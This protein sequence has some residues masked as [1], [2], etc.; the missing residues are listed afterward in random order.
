MP[1]CLLGD[2]CTAAVTWVSVRGTAA[3]AAG[4]SV[5]WSS[6]LGRALEFKMVWIWYPSLAIGIAYASADLSAPLKVDSWE[7]L[8]GKKD[9]VNQQQHHY[10]GLQTLLRFGS[11]GAK[12]DSAWISG[13]CM[14]KRAERTHRQ[15]GKRK[16]PGRWVTDLP[17]EG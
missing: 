9:R 15:K 7:A 1:K 10:F 3:A 13:G 4:A 5:I 6:N 12:R 17:S 11:W 16:T 2:H 8:I 14:R